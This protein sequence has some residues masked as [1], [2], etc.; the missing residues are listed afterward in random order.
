MSTTQ[1]ADRAPQAASYAR[2]GR[3]ATT[4]RTP[5]CV[6]DGGLYAV[7]DGVGD[8]PGPGRDDVVEVVGALGEGDAL[9]CPRR[10][11]HRGP[12]PWST[13]RYAEHA[14]RRPRP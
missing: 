11:G 12:R 7:A 4:S 6:T 1:H 8:A 2:A 14:R 9:R 13:E 5:S 3:R 10:R